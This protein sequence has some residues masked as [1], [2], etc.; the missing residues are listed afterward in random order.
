MDHVTKT[1]KSNQKGIQCD[2]CDLWYHTKCCSIGDEMYNILANSSCVWLCPLVSCGLPSF[3]DS[4]PNPSTASRHQKF[5]QVIDDY[6]LSQH[7]KAST[8]PI[9]G[10]VLDLLLSTYSNYIGDTS[11][12]SGLSDHLAVIL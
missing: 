5:L 3:S 10:R 7:V 8:R 1:V 11:N 4:L 2:H 9:S 12:D 6:S